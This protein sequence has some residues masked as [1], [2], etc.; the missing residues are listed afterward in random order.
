MFVPRFRDAISLLRAIPPHKAWNYLLLQWSKSLS[1]IL[2]SPILL[3]KPAFVHIEPTNRCN[4]CCPECPTG[5][6]LLTRPAGSISLTTYAALLKTLAPTAFYLNLYFQGEPLLHEQF[7]EM[8]RLAKARGLYVATATN[9]QHL[10]HDMANAIVRSGLDRI[11]IS[12]D[13]PNA[14]TY[15]AYRIG[16]NW[17]KV[18]QAVRHVREAKTSHH[19]SS[20]LIVLQC[21]LFASNETKKSEVQ[22]LAKNLGADTLEFKTLQVM[23]LGKANALLPQHPTH[24]RYLPNGHR[25][26]RLKKR[27]SKACSHIFNS[28]VITWNGEVVPCCYDKN[29]DYS[30]GNLNTLSLTELWNGA[31]RKAFIKCVLTARQKIGMCNNCDA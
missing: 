12:F 30:F 28:C 31:Q 17:D 13:G 22:L 18:L 5:A 27:S 7:P 25:G 3:G 14:E 1:R 8:V 19:T 6:G 23:D 4:L 15:E 10:D 29:A 9:A 2:G 20:P 26:Y 21:L 16:G 11:I 24:T